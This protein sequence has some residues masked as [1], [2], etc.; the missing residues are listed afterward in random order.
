VQA[1]IFWAAGSTI[2]RR[3]EMAYGKI[4]SRYFYVQTRH[5]YQFARTSGKALDARRSCLPSCFHCGE[6][7]NTVTSHRSGMYRF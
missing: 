2:S 5:I 1:E 3:F 7:E 6:E 4:N